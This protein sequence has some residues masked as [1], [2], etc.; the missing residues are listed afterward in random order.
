MGGFAMEFSQNQ[1][2]TQQMHLSHQMLQSVNFLM[3]NHM[4]LTTNLY[5]EVQNNP[6][7]EI[8]RDAQL[9]ISGVSQRKKKKNQEETPLYKKNPPDAATRF[10]QF[11]ESQADNTQG[12]QQNLWEQFTLT[13]K[14]ATKLALAERLI[15][16]LDFHGFT[17]V[18]PISL[19]DINN[20]LETPELLKHVLAEIQNLD[21]VGC[22][23]SGS[24][25]S[26]YVQALSRCDTGGK[27]GENKLGKDATAIVLFLLAG[28]LSLLEGL[29]LPVIV[30][31]LQKQQE[32]TSAN[33]E[34]PD[35][36]KN[37][38]CRPPAHQLPAKITTGMVES[39][40]SFIKTLDPLPARQFSAIQGSYIYPEISVEQYED[41]GEIGLKVILHQGLL[42]E[43][44]LSPS[45]TK[46]KENGTKLPKDKQQFIK[47]SLKSAQ[48]L[49]QSL[50]FRE[51][52][53][54]KAAEALVEMQ[55][56][57]FLFG[58]QA[59]RPLKM[60]D[61]AERIQVHQ[62]TISRF[63]KGKYLRCQWGIFE[64]KY[65]FS[66]QVKANTAE[67]SKES[68]KFLLKKILEE[69][70]DDRKPLSDQ[71]LTDILKERDITISRRTVTKYRQELNI[72]SSFD[73]K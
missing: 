23:T 53:L 26:L 73:R 44:I 56:D 35:S 63:A 12:I 49:L 22:C 55:R 24:E 40:I 62:S 67:H 5:E 18:A 64:I 28:N 72:D 43:I 34:P 16:T 31:K 9:D 4:E 10:Q 41:E 2:L 45:F 54:E 13:T 57:F 6:A 20:P 11:L 33:K 3:M 14:D 39:A 66:N 38:T 59:L 61:M 60:E 42:P 7:L 68:V 37:W 65:F 21:P 32:S 69:H 29:R 25:E 15:S 47:N 46:A 1:Q 50:D 70:P 36:T 30:K 51:N 19:L 48:E 17:Q 27:D 71:K 58:P 8:V 52:T